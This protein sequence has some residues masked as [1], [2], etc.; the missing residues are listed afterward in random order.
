[1]NCCQVVCDYY[2]AGNMMGDFSNNVFATQ[3]S[4]AQCVSE[5]EL[6]ASTNNATIPEALPEIRF[7]EEPASWIQKSM[8]RLEFASFMAGCMFMAIAVTAVGYYM[9]RSS[10]VDMSST[11][12]G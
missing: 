11:L 10:R 2:P 6:W 12:L 3:K 4:R 8:S 9:K 1:M 5:V 7:E